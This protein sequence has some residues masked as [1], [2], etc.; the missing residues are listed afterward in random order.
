[1]DK[2]PNII[3]YDAKPYDQE[4]FDLTNRDYN[5]NIHYFNGHLNSKAAPLAKGHNVVCAFVNDTIGSEVIGILKQLNIGLIVL[6]S[7]GYNNVDLKAAYNNIH[8]A[9]VPAYSPHAVAEH[10]VA[11]MLA[12]N[13]K[14]H[15]AYNRTREGNFSINGLLGFDMYGK[16]I[17]II[18]TGKIGR[19]LID[20]ALSLR[21][22]IT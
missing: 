9:R 15:R 3:F 22:P 13:R 5:F 6:R 1:M 16:T 14:I 2:T 12:L 8:V 20:I 4:S 11:L 17:G 18:G 7:A 19:C 10:A 21:R